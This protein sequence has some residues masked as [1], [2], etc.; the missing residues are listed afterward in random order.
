MV[1]AVIAQV[2]F[3]D[4]DRRSAAEQLAGRQYR[5]PGKDSR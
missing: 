2:D 4:A 3:V 1:D 5:T